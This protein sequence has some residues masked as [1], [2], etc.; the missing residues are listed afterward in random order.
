MSAHSPGSG[1]SNSVLFVLWLIVQKNV[2]ATLSQ[3]VRVALRVLTR[4][5]FC[6]NSANY[7]QS[8]LADLDS[9]WRLQM[10]DTDKM[11]FMALG[12]ENMPNNETVTLQPNNATTFLQT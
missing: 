6:H 11:L 4:Y 7:Y 10:H 9:D 3:R 12:N 5:P 1:Y 2:W 8:G